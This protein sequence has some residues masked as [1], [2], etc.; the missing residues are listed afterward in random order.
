[1][2]YGYPPRQFGIAV[3]PDLPVSDLSTWLT[4]RTLMTY[5]IRQHLNRDK[6]R[7]KRQ[8]DTQR[9]ERQFQ[10]GNMVYVPLRSVVI[11]PE[12]QSETSL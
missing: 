4:N 9:S 10:V 3:A 6:Q 2:L 12:E 8:A 7:M 11:G 1:M 5:V